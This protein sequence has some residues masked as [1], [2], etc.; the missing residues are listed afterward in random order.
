MI[1]PSIG[2]KVENESCNGAG[3][4]WDTGGLLA[5]LV[6]DLELVAFELFGTTPSNTLF[7]FTSLLGCERLLPWVP[8]PGLATH[9]KSSFAPLV[10]PLTHKST[11]KG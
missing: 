8:I 5:L 4:A 2:A 6:L 11:H 3:G 10:L 7:P 9:A 1:P